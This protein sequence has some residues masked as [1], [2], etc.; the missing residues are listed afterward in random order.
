ME[1]LGLVDTVGRPS[2]YQNSTGKIIE[3]QSI[4]KSG[5]LA[6]AAARAVVAVAAAAAAAAAD[7]PR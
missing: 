1:G 4:N 6:L 3:H 7:D 2:P 5:R